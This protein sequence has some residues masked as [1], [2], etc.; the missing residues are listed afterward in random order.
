MK[1]DAKPRRSVL[2]MPGSNARALHKARNLPADVLIFDLEDAVAPA[3]KGD[4][5]D[6]V[7]GSIADG[8]YEMRERV[9]RVN[10]LDSDW[11]DA[12]LSAIAVADACAVL[13]PK[14]DRAADV[15]DA[16][17]R[18]NAAGI[19]P[20]TPLWVMAETP[21]GVLNIAE[22]AQ[23]SDRLECI[24]VGTSDLAKELRVPHTPG[25]LGLL[26]SLSMCVLAARAVGA[27]VLDGVFLDLADS[28]GFAKA[29]EQGRNL[30]FDGKTLIHPNQIEAANRL[31]SPSTS[32]VERAARVIEAWQA[33]QEAGEGVAVVDGRLVENLHFEEASRLLALDAA[34]KSRGH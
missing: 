27:D 2:Y 26:A 20:S 3:R 5:R 34:I 17:R 8:G 18:M 15:L 29:C 4:A 30:G 10:G 25:R 24:V 6:L 19:D 9:V 16:E 1:I 33:A 14:I 31:F 7:G 11:C 23:A 28:H 13:F 22:I 21:L 32:D 12:D